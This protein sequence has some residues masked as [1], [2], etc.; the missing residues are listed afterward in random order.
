MESKRS[1]QRTKYHWCFYFI[2]YNKRNSLV[3]NNCERN[4]ENKLKYIQVYVYIYYKYLN[5]ES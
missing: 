2:F 1:F 3:S 5:K 4:E